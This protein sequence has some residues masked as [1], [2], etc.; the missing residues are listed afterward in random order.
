MALVLMPIFAIGA[1]FGAM[2]V[3]IGTGDLSTMSSSIDS[4]FM[5]TVGGLVGLA[6]AFHTY[7]MAAKKQIFNEGSARVSIAL[8]AIGG[9]FQPLH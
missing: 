8:L 1:Y 2:D 7:P 5:F 4:S 3:M 6:A 9:F